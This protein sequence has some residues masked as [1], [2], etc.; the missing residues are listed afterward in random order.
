[1]KKTI[2]ALLILLLI[3]SMLFVLTGCGD[4]ETAEKEDK[5]EAVEQKQE[6]N[7]EQEEK[8]PEFSMGEWNNKVYTND[9]LG[10]K[11]NLPEGWTY[12]SEAEIAQM[13][14]VGA[15]L[16]NDDQ[17]AAAEI[18]KLTSVYYMV[19]Q[20]SN[21]GNNVNIFS[22]KQLADITIEEYINALETQLLAVQSMN[23]KVEGTS[24]EKIGNIEADTLTLSVTASGIEIMQKYYIYKIDKYMI[25]IIATSLN[26]ETGINEIA[27]CF[28]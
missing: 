2:K 15:E 11:Y 12:S 22:E 21:T 26:G 28:E 17:K 9:F 19:A 7:V 4:K 18:A 8:A 1:M 27:K 25:G 3:A 16:L 10:L 5:E 20:D 14:S 23:Y 13:M 24:K 6:T